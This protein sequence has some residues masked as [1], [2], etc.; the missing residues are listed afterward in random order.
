MPEASTKQTQNT[1]F[2]ESH[3]PGHVSGIPTGSRE[4]SQ[5]T[6]PIEMSVPPLRK[7]GSGCESVEKQ[8]GQ[9]HTKTRGERQHSF[10][11][12]VTKT[13]EEIERMGGYFKKNIDSL[14][15][16]NSSVFTKC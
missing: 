11:F 12:K 9:P 4:T 7:H 1:H 14:F 13:K 6:I 5:S 8:K 16:K 3:S 2:R 15:K 10:M